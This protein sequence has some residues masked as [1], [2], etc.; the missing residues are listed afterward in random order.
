VLR[1]VL[2]LLA[3]ER[4]VLD[5]RAAVFAPIFRL[6]RRLVSRKHIDEVRCT[7][8]ISSIPTC[9]VTDQSAEYHVEN[10]ILGAY[11]RM[12]AKDIFGVAEPS[13]FLRSAVVKGLNATREE[14]RV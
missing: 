3:L 11:G 13:N 14:A 7:P 12:V 8:W 4:R 6:F 2:V 9:W 5:I 1:G 10:E